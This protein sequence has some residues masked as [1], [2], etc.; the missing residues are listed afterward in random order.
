MAGS[1]DLKRFT[2]A[3]ER[4]YES[5]L[6][7]INS[8]RK[9]SHWMWYIFPQ[10][11]GLGFSS[12]S[13]YYAINNGDEAMAYLEHPVLGKRL[14]DICNA[15][16]SL[17]GNNATLIFGSPDDVKL[18]S[19]VTLFATLPGADDVFRKVLTKFFAGKEDQATLEKLN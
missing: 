1:F 11:Q 8:G 13:K 6:A 15:L 16:L 19:C 9:R 12:I 4:D 17:E 5:A 7:E 2:E 14:V 18:K 3:Q 10:I